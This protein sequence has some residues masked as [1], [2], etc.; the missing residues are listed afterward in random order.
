VSE[1]T[2]IPFGSTTAAGV[3]LDEPAP[4]GGAKFSIQTKLGEAVVATFPATVTIPAGERGAQFLLTWAAT[5]ASV[6]QAQ[7]TEYDGAAPTWP[8]GVFEIDI[9]GMAGDVA[10]LAAV[11]SPN[12][13][14]QEGTTETL[15]VVLTR[16]AAG[17]ITVLLSSSDPTKATVPASVIVPNG[18]QYATFTLTGVAFG[19][20]VVTASYSG[21]DKVSNVTVEPVE[22]AAVAPDELEALVLSTTTA[23]VTFEAPVVRDEVVALSSDPGVTVPATVTVLTGNQSASFDVTT[24]TLG[25]ATVTATHSTGVKTCGIVVVARGYGPCGG[26]TPT[27]LSSEALVPTILSSEKL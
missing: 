18:S 11:V 6:L 23:Q 14:L 22:I 16:E 10:A 25:T 26:H 4:A 9:Y 2:S 21:V 8:T 27:I 17:D 12:V 13:M 20:T 1:V 19:S 7:L 24:V 3:F 15:A 5:G